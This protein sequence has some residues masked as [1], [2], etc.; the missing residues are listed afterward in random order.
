M[1]LRVSTKRW[2]LIEVRKSSIIIRIV[3]WLYILTTTLFINFFKHIEIANNIKQQYINPESDI[4]KS[5]VK[6]L[7]NRAV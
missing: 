4:R 7:F 2:S 5:E 6:Y 1:T 3:G